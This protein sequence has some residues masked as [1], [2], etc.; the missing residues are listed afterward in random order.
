MMVNY[1][2]QCPEENKYYRNQT[3]DKPTQPISPK[4]HLEYKPFV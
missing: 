3:N 4:H 2:F 1:Y